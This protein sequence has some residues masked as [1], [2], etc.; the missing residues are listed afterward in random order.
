MLMVVVGNIPRSQVEAAVSGTL[1]RLPRG[2]YVWSLPSEWT[3]PRASVTARQ[4]QLPT[5]YILG[6]FS[7]PLSDSRDYVPFRVATMLLGGIASY[8]IRDSGLSYAAPSPFLDRA[9]SGGGVYVTTTRP[10]TTMKIFNATIE[11]LKENT[12]NRQMLQRYF[13]GF[14]TD[15][16]SEN[17][18]N[19]GRADFLARYEL[20]H[21]DWRLSARYMD[22]LKRV[23]GTHIRRAARQYMR[24]IQYVYIGNI[25]FSPEREMEKY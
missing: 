2:Q 10:D 24:N 17:E 14:I 16:Y 13:N 20:L 6:Y 11:L 4:R 9:A 5:N 25:Q 15:Y 12:L 21:G 18:S 19:A 1:A 22:D 7:G 8:E 23:E 3:A